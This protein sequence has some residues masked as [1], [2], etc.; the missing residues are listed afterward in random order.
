MRK[1]RGMTRKEIFEYLLKMKML[2]SAEVARILEEE[3]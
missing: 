2:T 1:R 3:E